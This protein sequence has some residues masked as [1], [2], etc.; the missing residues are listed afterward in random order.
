M[1][2]NILKVDNLIQILIFAGPS[3]MLKIIPKNNNNISITPFSTEY[4][5]M[6]NSVILK[7]FGPF[8]P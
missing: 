2:I 6:I 8:W 1:R 5:E 4:I 3:C 7:W